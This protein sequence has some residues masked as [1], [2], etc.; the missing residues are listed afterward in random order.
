V[1][2]HIVS[3]DGV[4]IDFEKL[5]R[6]SKLLFPTTKKT[7]QVFLE[8]VGYYQRFIHMFMTKACPLT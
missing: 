7:L 3:K 4:A 1:V 6:I 5:D 2:G 8:M